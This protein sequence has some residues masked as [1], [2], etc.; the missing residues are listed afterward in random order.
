MTKAYRF[1][2]LLGTGGMGTVFE[3]Q[4]ENLDRQVA[5]KLMKPELFNNP[6]AHRPAVGFGRPSPGPAHR[7]PAAIAA[8]G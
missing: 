8:Q 2:R 3:A 5:V 4:D 7:R 6:T 1:T